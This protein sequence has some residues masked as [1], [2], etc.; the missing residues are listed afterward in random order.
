MGLSVRVFR[1][2][3]V[4]AAA[5]VLRHAM[6]FL[7]TTAAALS[8]EVAGA[9][10]EQRFQMLVAEVDGRLVGVSRTGLLHESGTPGLGFGD[11]AVDPPARRAGVG[12]AL[13]AATERRLAGLGAHRA[14][15]WAVDE[16]DGGRFAERHGYRRGQS[17][18][19]LRLDLTEPLPKP[20]VPPP[21][22]RVRTCP[23]ADFTGDPRPLFAAEAESVADEPGD[24]AVD[25][26]TYPTW[27]ASTWRRPGLDRRWSTAVLV[28][29]EVAAFTLGYTAEPS[30]FWSG[31]TGT[32]RAYR[33]QG[34]AKLAKHHA[35][36]RAREAGALDAITG[37]ADANAP[38][39]AVN[40]WLGYRTV[41]TEARY[42]R[43]L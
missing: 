28:D 22:V 31:M 23:V 2:S 29:G 35:L 5:R 36:S 9:P 16:E 17:S 14:Y 27:L 12:A 15:S 30:R 37:N 38:M 32:R 20:P 24:V 33:G 43:E 10:P 1:P 42:S 7:F 13:L 18:R 19:F 21:G 39:L 6:P 3:D 40:S 26:L 25:A 41:S 8:W 4:E 11:V 34:L